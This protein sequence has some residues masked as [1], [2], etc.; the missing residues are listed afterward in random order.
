LKGG[1]LNGLGVDSLVK[2][3][4][5]SNITSCLDVSKLA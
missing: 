3:K 5:G 2:R 1:D 4:T